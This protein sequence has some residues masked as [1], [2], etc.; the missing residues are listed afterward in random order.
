MPRTFTLS[1]HYPG[2]VE[3]VYAAFADEQYWLARLADSGA[4]TVTLDSMTVGADGGVDVATTQGIHRDK[5][6]AL[7]AQFHPGD[8]EMARHEKWRPVRDGRAHAEVTGRIVGAPAKL[9]GDAVL[10][11]A[12][13]GC[14]LRL[15]ATVRVDIPLVGGKIENFIGTQL[16]EL[17]T[18]EQR[19]TAMWLQRGGAERPE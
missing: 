11:P 15:T 2:S 3:Q 1:E 18:A 9:S 7:A 8:L 17:M 16:T 13:G 6:P 14:A 5:L 19:F 10:E 4:D 12:T